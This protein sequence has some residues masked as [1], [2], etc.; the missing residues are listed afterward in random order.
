MA[1]RPITRR[2]KI[3]INGEEVDNTISN[4]NK[5]LAK[6]RSLANRAVE[7]TPEWKK[8]NTEVAKL[9]VELKKARNSQ[10]DFREETKL[11]TAGIKDGEKA[12][13]KF[14]SSFNDLVQGYRSGDLIQ[15]REGW[16]G[17]RTSIASAT[18]ATLAFIATPI[19]IAIAALA[20]IGIAAKSWFDYNQQ[21]VEALRLTTQLTGLTDRAADTARIRGEA[22]VETFDIDFK[23]TLLTANS[24][25]QQ[26]GISFDRAFDIIEADLVR[27]QKNNDEYFKSLNEY[28][29]FFNRAGFKAEEFSRIISTGFD[30][31]I[32]TDKL[33]DALKEATLSLEEQTD[34][35]KDALENA[36]G[37]EFT[38]RLFL[39]LRRGSITAKDAVAQIAEETDRLG[40]NSQQAQQLTA[41][42][43]K[44][45]GEDAGGALRIFEAVN[46][47][48]N[49]QQRELTESEQILE[50]QVEATR[51]LKQVSS[52]LFATGDAGFGLIIDKAKLFG[53]QVLVEI[54]KK[55]VDL[56]N[57]F[58]DL[59]NKSATFSGVLAVISE[60]GTAS[61]TILVT[62]F[63][64]LGGVVEGVGDVI[65][66]IFTGDFDQ[67]NKGLLKQAQAGTNFFNDLKEKG[68]DA[69]QKIKEAFAG[70]NQLE[71]IQLGDF[72]SGGGGSN[73]Q[74]VNP[75]DP[76]GRA[77]EL[78]PEDKRVL[79]SRKKL[80]EF[81]KQI[82]EEEEIQ[83]ELKKLEEDQRAEEE[84]ILR[85]ERKFQKMKE[86]A[87]LTNEVAA[88]LS[89]EERSLL[90]QLEEAKEFELQQ[91]RDKYAKIREKKDEEE[92]K[93]A[94]ERE[95]KFKEVQIKA[96]QELQDAK[97]DLL[98]QGI[99]ALKGFFDE[100]SSIYK[101]L[102]LAEKAVTAAQVVLD[103]IAER[104]KIS[105]VWGWN[106][107]ISGPL[108]LAS[109]IRTIS[110]LATIA[111]TAIQ[112]FEDGGETFPGPSSGGV[113]GRGGRLAILHPD[114][115]VIPKVVR[116]D[117]EVPA[118]IDYLESK[119]RSKLGSF[120]IGGEVSPRNN[121]MSSPGYDPMLIDAVNKLI[122]K[123][124]EPLRLLYTLEDEIERRKLAEKLDTTI[125]ESKGK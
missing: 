42:L 29:T 119:R 117:P 98:S 120:E 15:I 3:Y 75:A 96:E 87:G 86:E 25:V 90:S 65:E 47:A 105:A 57:W 9:E 51:E 110:S 22:L 49:Q 113:D 32:Y 34:T 114:E 18:R 23:E 99:D 48:L 30:L 78:T 61:L 11:S 76:N 13:G 77:G 116:Q 81:L 58:I 2:L 63:Q 100:S 115:Y 85:L 20:G 108:L 72:T 14:T 24:L 17:V 112:G 70:N 40:L 103:G 28:A 19:G 73:Q 33:P 41:D 56:T 60:V 27:G 101:A 107:A 89:D 37:R 4:I 64:N 62:A 39:N 95:R 111:S 80:K 122:E 104:S 16:Q 44:G 21:V 1:D 123:L 93:K 52:A 35:A 121:S 79:E 36:F 67:I 55:G 12:I 54:L 106:P 74:P 83:N 97:R 43:F 69:A 92:K 6:F 59:N 91:V 8:Y 68:V 102:F 7:G 94:S 82:E 10:R 50:D 5:N 26:F 38:D 31:G 66:G 45:A 118:L 46:I 125:N 53:T 109:K 71:R 124:D 88:E 84:D